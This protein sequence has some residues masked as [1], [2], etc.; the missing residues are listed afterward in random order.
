M[1]TRSEGQR[2]MKES[3]VNENKSAER[4]DSGGNVMI[5][6][7]P[8][9]LIAARGIA[10]IQIFRNCTAGRTRTNFRLERS[11]CCQRPRHRLRIIVRVIKATAM[12]N[13]KLC[14]VF[15]HVAKVRFGLF[16]FVSDSDLGR[17]NRES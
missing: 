7:A 2:A 5:N 3:R 9:T 4:S 1:E 14:K 6:A 16:K 15:R 8:R 13:N 17:K 12:T 11:S 10:A